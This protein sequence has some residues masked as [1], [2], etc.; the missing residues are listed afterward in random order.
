MWYIV[1]CTKGAKLIYGLNRSVS[2][3]ELKRYIYEDRIT[4]IC[5]YV[6]VRKGDAFFIPS[7]TI[8]A[9]GEGILIAEVQQ[10]S[11]IT[12]RVSDY[13]RLGADGK[14]RQLHKEKA[15]EVI[16][17]KPTPLNSAA[18]EKVIES[19]VKSSRLAECRYFTVDI[20]DICGETE[21]FSPESF[22][23]I[24]MLEGK[25]ELSFEG[26]SI[27]IAPPASV[28]VPAGMRVG[29]KGEAKLLV[30]KV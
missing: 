3:E 27:E 19:G 9:I 6:P 20:L 26:G 5:N 13:G 23:S 25:A 18:D 22:V 30:S 24:L 28:F 29:I 21:I 17:R 1:D 15:L 14:P 2:D 11:N 10:N 4:E 16:S 7:G 12:Y 8:H